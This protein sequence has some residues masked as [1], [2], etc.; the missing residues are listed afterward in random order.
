MNRDTVTRVNGVKE[1]TS[2]TQLPGVSSAQTLAHTGVPD[3]T[4]EKQRLNNNKFL[5]A[6]Q[7]LEV[8][9]M[10]IAAKTFWYLSNIAIAIPHAC[11]LL[12]YVDCCKHIG[13]CGC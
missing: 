7:S 13:M 2:G 1:I 3:M 8:L 9:D 5:A 4:L 11:T 6:Q 10:L 12:Q